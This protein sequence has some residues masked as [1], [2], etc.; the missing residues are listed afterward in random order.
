MTVLWFDTRAA[1]AKAAL[2][3]LATAALTLA[4]QAAP[5]LAAV[6]S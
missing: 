6:T 4:A 5:L 3:A 2:S 1:F